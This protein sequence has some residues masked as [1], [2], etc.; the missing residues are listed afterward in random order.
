MK[1][2]IIA[3]F[4]IMELILM[5]SFNLISYGLTNDENEIVIFK[6]MNLKKGLLEYD[7]N[8]DGELSIQEMENINEL[9]LGERNITDLTGLEHATN[10]KILDLY[11][12]NIMDI[13][14][15]SNLTNLTDLDLSS[16]AISNI[17]VLSG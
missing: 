10:L 5:L 7:N 15:L 9:Y 12:N 14:V 8:R 16:N 13:N 11:T 2:K 17:D 1:S 6:D 4:V 3:I